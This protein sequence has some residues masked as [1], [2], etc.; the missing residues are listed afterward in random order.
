MTRLLQVLQYRWQRRISIDDPELLAWD[1]L[2][3]NTV[4]CFAIEA[5]ER[6]DNI[7]D[8]LLA[9]IRRIYYWS[10]GPCE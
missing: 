7:E 3:T 8:D 5:R 1:S 9:L 10:L 4:V 2:L 6:I